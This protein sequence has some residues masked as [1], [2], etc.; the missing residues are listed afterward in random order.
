MDNKCREYFEM[1]AKYNSE[2]FYYINYKHW[3][4][5]ADD[6]RTLYTKF[7]KIFKGE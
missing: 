1:Y 3:T 4:L 5:R 7:E 2:S 6:P